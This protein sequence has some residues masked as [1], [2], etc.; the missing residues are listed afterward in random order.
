MLTYR[1]A[2]GILEEKRRQAAKGA[3]DQPRVRPIVNLRGVRS[4]VEAV[5]RSL[6]DVRHR[7]V[8]KGWR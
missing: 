3:P 6:T 5:D 4:W 2:K 7:I 1:S 8:A